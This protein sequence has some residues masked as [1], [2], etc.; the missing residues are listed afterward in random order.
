MGRNSVPPSICL[1][2]FQ[3]SGLRAVGGVRELAGGVWGPARS[4]WGPARSY[5]ANIWAEIWTD[6]QNFCPI[7]RTLSPIGAAAQKPSGSLT[8]LTTLCM[9]EEAN[10]VESQNNGPRIADLVQVP[11]HSFY[12]IN[13]F[14]IHLWNSRQLCLAP[15]NPLLRGFTVRQCCFEWMC[16]QGSHPLYSLFIK[17]LLFQLSYE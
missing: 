4:A 9:I 1:S 16:M 2:V 12:S 17:A 7:Y 15:P 11:G 13:I 3:P 8:S 5:G 10:I 6:V 14:S